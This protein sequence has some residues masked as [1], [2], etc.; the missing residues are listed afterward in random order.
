LFSAC[1][2]K[3]REPTKKTLHL[4]VSQDPTSFDPRCVR[5][6]K[7]LTLSKQLFEGLMRFDLNNQVANALAESI[8][9][10]ESKTQY[11][12]SLR[13]ALWSNGEPI[14]ADD[15]VRSWRQAC[16][17]HFPTDYAHM[18]F[19]IKNAKEIKEGKLPSDQ[20]GVFALDAETLV[21]QL[22]QPTPYFLELTAFPTYFPVH[23]SDAETI[24]SGPFQLASYKEQSS[25]LLEKNPLHWDA[26]SVALDELSFSIINDGT[27]EFYL[28]QK[29]QIDWLGQP[30]S[31]SLSPEVLEQNEA[32]S[33]NVAGTAWIVFNT[34]QAP[35]NNPTIRKALSVAI[36][37]NSIIQ[38][39]LLGG[40]M[41][42]T[43]VLPPSM[44]LHQT[45]YFQ[46]GDLATAQ[47]LLKGMQIPPIVLSCRS[48][49]REKKLMELVQQCWRQE[50]GLDVTIE[51]LESTVFMTRVK[52]GQFQA[53][54]RQW[55]ADFNDPVAFLELFA[56]SREWG[57]NDSNWQ[58]PQYKALLKNALVETNLDKR[59]EMLH[60]AEMLL[61]EQMAVAPLYHYSFD[62]LKNPQVKDVVL[63]PLGTADFKYSHIH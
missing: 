31:L 7:D 26:E 34:D 46:D 20:L 9:L 43:S 40:Q 27:T 44:R 57:M 60:R 62:Y 24:F 52:Q 54:L 28:F 61:M 5:S 37:R 41:A 10:D 45:P 14:T 55:I 48:L 4:N 8:D 22:A 53:A 35:F 11:T 13:K 51:T 21:V 49:T 29:G 2:T 32:S 47:E 25:L 17:P 6:I 36:S 15:F 18:L 59:K 33:Y 56:E 58:N 19:V 16:S 12:F 30:M 39:L 42:A 38:H 3:E 1:A 23:A 63:S 50:L